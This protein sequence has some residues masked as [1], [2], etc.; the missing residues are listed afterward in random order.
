MMKRIAFFGALFLSAQAQAAGYEYLGPHGDWDVFADKKA[1]ASVCYIAS[2]PT[3][4]S[5]EK[6]RGEIYALITRRKAEGF[7]DV[8][9]FHQGYPLKDGKDIAVSVGK[10]KF[11]LFGSGETAWTYESKDDVRLVKMMKAGSTLQVK[12]TSRRGTDT[13]DTYSLKGISAAYNAMKKACS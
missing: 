6:K 1:K 12:A 5:H 8:V 13:S 4:A 7:K 9:S 3:Q 10:A 2:A 11:N